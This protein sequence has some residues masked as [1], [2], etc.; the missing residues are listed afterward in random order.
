MS[1]STDAA[2][3]TTARP[4]SLSKTIRYFYGVGDM[5]FALMTNVGVYY[6]AFYITNVAQLSLGSIAFLTTV[7]ALIDALTSWIYGG[8]INSIK[9]MKWGRYRSWLVAVTWLVPVFYFFNVCPYWNKRYCI[10]RILFHF[11]ARWTLRKQLVIYCKYVD[12]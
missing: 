8:V 2:V 5:C 10:D 3:N 9:P 6:S 4:K 12:D 1:Q 11:H 7:V